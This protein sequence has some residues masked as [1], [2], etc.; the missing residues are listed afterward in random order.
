MTVA[1]RSTPRR[2]T[3]RRTCSPVV[4]YT[5]NGYP[6]ELEAAVIDYSRSVATLKQI[7]E[8]FGPKAVVWSYDPILISS[9]TPPEHH[10]ESFAAL[11]RALSGWVDEVVVSFAHFYQKTRGNLTVA[12]REAGFTFDDPQVEQK[13]HL[14][15]TLVHMA[16]DHGMRL[17]ICSQRAFLVPGAAEAQ[18]VDA[19]RL[20]A[21]GAKKITAPVAGNREDCEC[22]QSK[23]IGEYNTCP[24]GCVYCYAVQNR[25]LAQDRFRRHDPE[26]DFLF[27]PPPGAHEVKPRQGVLSLPLLTR[28]E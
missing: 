10:L 5:I 9:L 26:S 18:C 17:S 19:R 4:Q 1:R 16:V 11:A 7:S 22:F 8:E 13:Q 14:L 6:R 21:V 2:C 15:T 27:E 24:H 3:A 25:G 20:E 28:K 12:A 23:D